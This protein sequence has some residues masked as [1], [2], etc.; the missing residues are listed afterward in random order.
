MRNP[1][2]W[3]FA[4]L[5]VLSPASGSLAVD[6]LNE[7]KAPYTLRIWDESAERE[8]NIQP[9]EWLTDICGNCSIA[10]E[11]QDAVEAENDDLVVIREGT[12]LNEI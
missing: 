7:D 1:L 9:G 11:E 10:L 2:Y 12:L 8:I 6:I 5:L 3:G 4:L